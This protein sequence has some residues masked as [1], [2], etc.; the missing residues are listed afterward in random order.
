MIFQKKFLY[1]VEFVIYYIDTRN[2]H[3]KDSKKYIVK[4][5]NSEQAITK[6]Y[7]LLTKETQY[8]IFKASAYSL[9]DCREINFN[10]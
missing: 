8:S 6:A 7:K 5:R 4:A 10:K 1:E 3:T 9:S 2:R